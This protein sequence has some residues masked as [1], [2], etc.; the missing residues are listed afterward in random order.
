MAQNKYR[1]YEFEGTFKCGHEGTV[2]QGG[3]TREY[4]E[5]SADYIF[6]HEECPECTKKKKELEHKEIA[7]RAKR[8]ANKLGFPELTG[9]PKQIQWAESIR[10]DFYEQFNKFMDELELYDVLEILE[11]RGERAF[12]LI[13]N[14]RNKLEEFIKSN[15]IYDLED[16]KKLFDEIYDEF[17]KNIATVTMNFLEDIEYSF[18][19]IDNRDI[20]KSFYSFA[21]YLILHMDEKYLRTR[22]EKVVDEVIE[23]LQEEIKEEQLVVP[24]NYNDQIC[25]IEVREDEIN[26]ST[27]KNE[28][29]IDFVKSKLYTWDYKNKTWHKYIDTTNNKNDVV[30][31]LGNYLLNLGYGVRFNGVGIEVQNMAI[32]GEFEKENPRKIYISEDRKILRVYWSW[33]ERGFYEEAKR[34]SGAVWSRKNGCM[35]IPIKSYKQILDFAEIN[36]FIFSS[37]AMEI[38]KAYEKLLE[39]K[40]Q[41]I[42]K[43]EKDKKKIEKMLEDFDPDLLKELTDD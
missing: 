1:K 33:K 11:R 23:E 12:I 35:E 16:E 17:K 30:A 10:K 21:N 40:K 14:N 20:I 5:D 38:I 13:P 37:K 26:L 3:Y 4:A 15:D 39:D 31:E 43:V 42:T 27:P 24:E 22:D 32:K 2:I 36:D 28:E 41:E 34:I 18:I 25:E 7:E 9:T 8:D 19:Y 6:E 29:I